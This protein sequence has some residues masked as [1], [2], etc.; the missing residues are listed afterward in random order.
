MAKLAI[1]HD[2]IEH[3]LLDVVARESFRAH[4]N[5]YHGCGARSLVIELEGVLTG[6]R[7]CARGAPRW[8]GMST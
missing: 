1:R 3:R 7:N 2:L 8:A 4:E 5:Q 6:R